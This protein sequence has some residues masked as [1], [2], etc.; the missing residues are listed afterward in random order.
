M[1]Y[2]YVPPDLTYLRRDTSVE[3]LYLGIELEISGPSGVQTHNPVLNL[4]PEMVYAKADSSV[5]RG[6]E[7]VTV[8]LAASNIRELVRPLMV[9]LPAIYALGYRSAASGCCGIHIHLSRVAF[10]RLQLY[11]FLFMVYGHPSLSLLLS[12]RTAEAFEMWALPYSN[13]AE[14]KQRAF[15]RSQGGRNRHDA[16][17]ISHHPTIELRIFNGSLNLLTF[18]KAIDTALSLFKYAMDTPE[19]KMT[20]QDY[21]D[22]VSIHR[23]WYPFLDVFLQSPRR[24]RGL[25]FD[26]DVPI[27]TDISDTLQHRLT[28]LY[29]LAMGSDYVRDNAQAASATPA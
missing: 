17:N 28:K 20:A 26:G 21:I 9:Q 23:E 8:P 18:H 29:K 1:R 4:L 27:E 7:V 24:V 6:F 5:E 10:T 15:T 2:S 22:F 19:H 12:Q 14:H 16:V 3:E 13:K 11:K 25:L